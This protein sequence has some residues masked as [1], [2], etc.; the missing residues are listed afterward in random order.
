MVDWS[1]VDW[2]VVDWSG[3][4]GLGGLVGGWTVFVR[5]SFGG[6]G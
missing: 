1:V 5:V 3:W 4:V 6:F 2:S